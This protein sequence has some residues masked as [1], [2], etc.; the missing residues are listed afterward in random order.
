[1]PAYKDQKKGTW[2]VSFYYQDW[3][4]KRQKKL[5]RGFPTK[6]EA[7]EW[8]RGFLQQ[9]VADLSMTFEQ[10]VALYI[11]DMKGRIRKNTWG[12]KE[13]IMEPLLNTFIPVKSSATNL[14]RGCCFQ[15]R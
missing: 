7:L 9:K 1:M 3:T 11:A 6:R 5:K 4:G 14:L 10:F 2:Y 13:H 15:T 8:E 12:P